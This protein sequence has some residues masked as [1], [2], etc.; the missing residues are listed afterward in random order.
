MN[1]PLDDGDDEYNLIEKDDNS[2]PFA[3]KEKEEES[4]IEHIPECLKYEPVYNMQ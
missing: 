2:K 1:M 3:V 4:I